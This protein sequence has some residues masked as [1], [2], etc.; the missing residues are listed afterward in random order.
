[1]GLALSLSLLCIVGT[2][3]SAT[4]LVEVTAATPA[5]VLIA[6]D[7]CPANTSRC[8][9]SL[10]AIFSDICCQLGQTCAFDANNKP[11]CCPL[12]AVCTGTAPATPPGGAPSPEASYV[13]NA[14]FSFPFAPTSYPN[15]ASCASAVR[16][17]SHNYDA[18]VTA[19]HG[20][21]GTVHG[22][23]VDVPGGGGTTV[24]PGAHNLGSSASSVCA[25][26]STAA[27]ATLDTKRCESFG[28]NSAAGAMAKPR[29]ASTLALLVAAGTLVSCILSFA[30]SSH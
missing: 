8:P 27:C 2:G 5:P 26:L 18:C 11:A 23:T 7:E 12:G 6:R 14:Y 1:M 16:A 17:C 30:A 19:L 24:A 28:Q 20:T 22:V 9:T 29:H 10:G 21:D 4:K 13:P 15:S 25:S 3:C